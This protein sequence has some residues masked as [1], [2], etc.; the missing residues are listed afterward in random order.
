MRWTASLALIAACVVTVA[1][2]QDAPPSVAA[3]GKL[4]PHWEQRPV[5]RDFARHYPST[6]LNNDMSGIAILCCAPNDDGRLACRHAFEWPREY[7]FGDAAVAIAARFR[8]SEDSVALYRATPG[9]WL[10]IP[11][12]M[13]VQGRHERFTPHFE[14]VRAATETLCMPAADGSL[15]PSAPE[16]PG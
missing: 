8:M 14:R 9:A 4:T 13:M 7:G 10:Q 6:A 5:A 2:A 12:T 11:I 3:N 15:R 16:A 1:L